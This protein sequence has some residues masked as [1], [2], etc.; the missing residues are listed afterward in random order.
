MRGPQDVKGE[1]REGDVR[2]EA[3]EGGVRGEAREGGGWV[4][5]TLAK[6]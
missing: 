1:P 3:R 6:G 4:R 5:R 2:G